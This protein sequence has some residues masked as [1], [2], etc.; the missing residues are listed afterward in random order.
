[1]RRR[2]AVA[3]GDDLGFV[4]EAVALLARIFDE[5]VELASLTAGL[6]S[7]FRGF[8]EAA[9][10]E[11]RDQLPLA[12]PDSEDARAGGGD[13]GL[14]QRRVALFTKQAVGEDPT[15]ERGDNIFA[16]VRMSY[17]R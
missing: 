9:A 2:E 8:D 7:D 10:A 16:E 12:L 17:S 5:A 4:R 15:T 3:D 13:R 14:A 1:M 11:L 6:G